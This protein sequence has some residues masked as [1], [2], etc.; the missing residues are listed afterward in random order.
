[1]VYAVIGLAGMVGA[2]LRYYL[3]L[4][5]HWNWD[6]IFPLGTLITNYIG[7][8]ALGWFTTWVSTSAL[9][10]PLIRAGIG[11]GLIGSFTTFSTFSVETMKLLQAGYW[12]TALA[13]VLLSVWGGLTLAWLGYRL[14]QANTVD[15]RGEQSR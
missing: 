4:S 9:G 15:V 10:H 8:F 13:Y 5:V 14:A 2:L 11:T 6:M 7:S 1:M 3:G 12:A